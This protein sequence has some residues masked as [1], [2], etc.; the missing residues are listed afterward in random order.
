MWFGRQQRNALISTLGWRLQ[1]HVQ[2]GHIDFVPYVELGWN[3]DSRAG[4]DMVTA[5]L[6]SMNGS[7][8]MAGFMPDQNWG[9]VNA[10]LSA[11]LT[12]NLTGW[13]AYNGFVANKSQNLNG[14]NVGVKYG[15]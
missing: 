2:T 5:G 13:I 15:F 3:H 4:T 7:F 9:S 10:G 8:Q 1:G 11:Q 6:N 14:I 12:P